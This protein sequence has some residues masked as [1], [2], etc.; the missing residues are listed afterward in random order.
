LKLVSARRL[1]L[2]V[3]AGMAVASCGTVATLQLTYKNDR[4]IAADR[5]HGLVLL[6][7]N[8]DEQNL[9]VCRGVQAELAP[10]SGPQVGAG[11]VPT[12]W[13]DVRNRAPSS[14]GLSDT[15]CADLLKTYDYDRAHNWRSE[16]NARCHCL[17]P[18]GPALIAFNDAHT[19]A[20]ALDLS[21]VT[22]DNRMDRILEVWCEEIVRPPEQWNRGAFSYELAK[23][24]FQ[25]FAELIGMIFQL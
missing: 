13:L 25:E 1:L 19:T 15:A 3:A 24:K 8:Q 21:H 14:A 20:F 6:V 7:K 11:E 9:R 12:Y 16:I 10:R 4:F 23:A 17:S 18:T 22:D 2:V 5:P